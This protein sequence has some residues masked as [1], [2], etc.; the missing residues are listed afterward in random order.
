MAPPQASPLQPLAEQVVPGWSDHLLQ[1][2][3]QEYLAQQAAPGWSEHVPVILQHC[4][5]EY[6]A[7]QTTSQ[8]SIRNQKRPHEGS[9]DRKNAKTSRTGF[10]RKKSQTQSIL[11]DTTMNK[12]PPTELELPSPEINLGRKPIRF[13][14]PFYKSNSQKHQDCLRYEL[15]RVKDVKQHIYRKHTNPEFY[16]ARCFEEFSTAESRDKHTVEP[17]C[18]RKEEF[19]FDGVS[20]SQRKSLQSYAN[21]TKSAQDQWF[22]TWDIIFPDQSRPSTCYVGN[23][24][25][26]ITSQ[27]R[28]FWSQKQAEIFSSVLGETS[29]DG[30]SPSLL[31]KVMGGLFDG[32]ESALLSS[33]PKMDAVQSLATVHTPQPRIESSDKKEKESCQGR[34]SAETKEYWTH[35]RGEVESLPVDSTGFQWL[36]DWVFDS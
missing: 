8:D 27:L 34:G 25:E 20:S 35:G 3:C 4:D 26:E 22:S 21:R 29:F 14:C 31:D 9:Q 16:C 6:L 5:Q 12:S 10:P 19:Q 30:I 28:D 18:I 11:R 1:H 23:Y 2:H 13:A 24:A 17:R 36:E 7:E 33:A 15:R 32:F